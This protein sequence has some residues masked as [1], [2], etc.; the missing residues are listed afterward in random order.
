MVELGENEPGHSHEFLFGRF[1][2]SEQFCDVRPPAANRSRRVRREE[3]I[4]FFFFFLYIFK[5]KKK[6]K[7]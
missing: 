4:F 5:K 7:T 6:K 2:E 3:T 1:V